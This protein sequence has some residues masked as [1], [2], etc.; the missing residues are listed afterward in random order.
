MKRLI[1]SFLATLAVI[2][3]QQEEPLHE[4]QEIRFVA[5]NETKAKSTLD[6]ESV[7]WDEGDKI[8]ILWAGGETESSAI[9]SSDRK[10]AEFVANVD[11]ADEYYAVYPYAASASLES[12]KILID[13]PENQT[14]AFKDCNITVAKANEKNELVF[15]HAVGYVEFSVW[16]IRAGTTCFIT[17]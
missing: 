10:V 3:C 13:L 6:N 8:Q 14:G 15:R 16:K 2:S 12:G 4:K 11:Q 1:F 5:T 7:L 9:V 17:I